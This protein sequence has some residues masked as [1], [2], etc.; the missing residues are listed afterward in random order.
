[1]LK[2]VQDRR[3]LSAPVDSCPVVALSMTLSVLAMDVPSQHVRGEGWALRCSTLISEAERHAM[4]TS[5]SR[6]A[7][8]LTPP[9]PAVKGGGLTDLRNG[10]IIELTAMSTPRAG[11]FE[12]T[13]GVA[14]VLQWE[15]P[16][17]DAWSLKY[18]TD[19]L[20]ASAAR[21]ACT[22]EAHTIGVWQEDFRCAELAVA[23]HLQAPL[24]AWLRAGD[25]TLA[26]RQS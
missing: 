13:E 8:M 3:A 23:R 15:P 7:R 19:D 2:V 5:C 24:Q 9:R 18:M 17:K 12:G 25:V 4:S 6:S 22:Y 21:D 20:R 1:V 16:A 26:N 10:S 14:D 11:E